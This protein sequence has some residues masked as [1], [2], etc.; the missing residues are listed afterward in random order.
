MKT[1]N[2]TKRDLDPKDYVRRSA[3]RKDFKTLIK[4]P[5]ILKHDGNVIAAYL[6]LPKL[7][8]RLLKAIKMIKYGTSNRSRGLVT[9]SRVFG[10]MPRESMRKDY[11]SS[12]AMACDYAHE[13][14]LVCNYGAEITKFYKKYCPEMFNKH[15]DL[16]Q[17]KV[18]PNW[19]LK[20]TPFTSGI[21]NKNSAL[22]YH[23]DAGNFNDVYSNMLAYKKDIEGGYLALPEYNV[24]LEIAN[25]SVLFFDGQKIL[26]GVTP[27][28]YKSPNAYRYTLVYYTLKQM[29]KCEE[30]KEELDRIKQVKTEREIKRL[31]RLT[32]EIPNEI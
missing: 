26:H 19:I 12:T 25:N 23:F 32:G 31:K 7:S 14:Q 5:C 30:P 2:L 27:I 15:N 20:G 11:C 22:N 29:W 8:V 18:K 10:Y 16:A 21:I 1:I 6:I 3:V 9:K 4:E 28:K 17:Q 13:H 24:G